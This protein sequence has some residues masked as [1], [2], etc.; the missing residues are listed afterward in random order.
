MVVKWL[1]KL[2]MKYVLVSN[3]KRWFRVSLRPEFSNI[4]D[5]LIL[6]YLIAQGNN[7]IDWRLLYKK[8]IIQGFLGVTK[9]FNKS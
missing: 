5:W 2:L 1:K 6:N 8:N 9:N 4:I 7:Y 3:S